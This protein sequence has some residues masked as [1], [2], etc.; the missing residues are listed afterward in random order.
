[1]QVFDNLNVTSGTTTSKFSD[2]FNI[3]SDTTRTTRL[4]AINLMVVIFS[5]HWIIG[6]THTIDESCSNEQFYKNNKQAILCSIH[7]L[8]TFLQE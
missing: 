3:T 2:S 5:F 1:M 7:G 8:Y 4:Q 6:G